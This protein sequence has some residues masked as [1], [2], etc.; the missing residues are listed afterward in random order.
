MSKLCVGRLWLVTLVEL[1]ATSVTV[2]ACTP[3]GNPVVPALGELAGDGAIDPGAIAGDGANGVMSNPVSSGA[4]TGGSAASAAPNGGFGMS[5]TGAAAN[6]AAGS[7]AAANGSSAG[8][9]SSNG[10][11][12]NAASASG[13]A[14]APIIPPPPNC[15][16]ATEVCDGVDNDCD[17][18][19]D[20]NVKKRC[21]ADLDGDGNAAAS[22]EV[23][24]TCDECGPM[25]TP[26]EPATPDATDCDD[27][28][29]TV[30]PAATDICGDKIDNDCNGK[31][32]DASNNAC[33]GPCTV[34]LAGKPGQA[35]SNGLKGACAKMGSYECLPDH[36]L[37]CSA[38]IVMGTPEKC[39]DN[40]DNDCDG[41]V[42][43]G[44]V[45][46]KCGGWTK[47]SPDAGASCS[48]GSGNC[49]GDGTYVCDGM[50][51]T[52]CNAKEKERNDCGGCTPLA[53]LGRSCT[54]DCSSSGTYV[55]SGTDATKCSVTAKGRN[56]C[57]GCSTLTNDVGKSCS[58]ACGARGSYV[59]APGQTDATMC[60]VTGTAT[61]NSC[62]GCS[63]DPPGSAQ[64]AKC[65]FGMNSCASIG[66][67]A[68]VGSGDSSRLECNAPVQ[69]QNTNGCGGCIGGRLG[70]QCPTTDASGNQVEG[71][72]VCDGELTFC[73]PR[74]S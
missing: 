12:S 48:V 68:C 54:A 11:G 18:H 65:T 22:A 36:T 1:L 67:W 15:I 34:Q 51:Q 29:K 19:T 26:K 44:C 7:G 61:R 38:E 21:W 57:G 37:K 71:V 8:A 16:P 24:E 46:N 73:E 31:V 35:C 41:L 42:D 27:N 47:L 70:T 64:G 63:A 43:N 28:D 40:S 72:Y 52:V 20:E 17:G 55:C 13:A 69:E 33:D 3:V 66:N 60:S 10:T 5:G 50:D 2:I 4:A 25:Q 9:S 6:G 39:G 23:V 74:T 45:K 59:C 62:Q 32:D 30:S 58:G 53:N 14:G 49:R 56:R